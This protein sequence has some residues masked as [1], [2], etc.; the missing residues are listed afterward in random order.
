MGK[1]S[2][3]KGNVLIYVLIAIALF[4]GLSFTLSRQNSGSNTNEL[5]DAKSEFYATQLIS[6]AAQVQSV[7]DQMIISGSNL[8]DLDFTLPGQASFSTPPFTHKV[9]HP[10]G[11]GLTPARLR[12]GTIHQ[13]SS[14]IPAGW[15]LGLFNNIEWSNTASTDAILTAYQIDKQICE[16]INMKITGNSVIPAL[17]GDMSSY[18][19]DSSSNS[20]LNISDCTACE[21]YITLCV[22]NDIVQAYSFY[23]VVADR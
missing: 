5:D 1:K 22:S 8:D 21:G 20:D 9:Y 14:T 18:L 12:K 11:G 17:S 2:T 15:Y 7:I 23:T 16:K 13:I 19:I 6:Y 4:A 10:Q 3:E